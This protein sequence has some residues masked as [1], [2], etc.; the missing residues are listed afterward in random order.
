MPA[1]PSSL[2]PAPFTGGFAE[3]PQ[4]NAIRFTPEV[5]PS[6]TRRRGTSRVTNVSITLPPMTGAQATTLEDFYRDD[7]KD[8]NLTFTWA[9][10]RTGASATFKFAGPYRLSHIALDL[11]QASFELE[12]L[13]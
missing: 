10:P 11:W 7:L 9:H 2:P 3:A 4:D 6:M 13:P 8:G 5:G 12:A 1:W